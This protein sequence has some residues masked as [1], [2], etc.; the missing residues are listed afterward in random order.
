[1]WTF[2]LTRQLNPESSLRVEG[3]QLGRPILWHHHRP[4]LCA[5]LWLLEGLWRTWQVP[6]GT[7]GSGVRPQQAR[8]PWQR[9]KGKSPQ[10]SSE[11]AFAAPCADCWSRC[12]VRK[13]QEKCCRE[14]WPGCWGPTGLQGGHSVSP[15]SS[16]AMAPDWTFLRDHPSWGNGDDGRCLKLWDF[17]NPI[18]PGVVPSES[19]KI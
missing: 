14:S 12:L 8:Q 15:S 9:G 2:P 10:P 13:K 16:W 4:R 5:G 6:A 17:L 18:V 1:M 11:A 7:G 3:A 19:Q